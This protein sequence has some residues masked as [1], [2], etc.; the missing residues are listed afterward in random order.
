MQVITKHTK[1]NPKNTNNILFVAFVLAFSFV[2]FV[3]NC[4]WIILC[5]KRYYSI[6]TSSFLKTEAILNELLIK[7]ILGLA[8]RST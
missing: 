5:G 1:F 6:S 7:S 4:V 8:F 2:L 3:L